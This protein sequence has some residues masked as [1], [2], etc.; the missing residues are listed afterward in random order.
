MN[1][2]LNIVYR[3]LLAASFLASLY[4][5]LHVGGLAQNLLGFPW[6]YVA[7][8]LTFLGCYIFLVYVMLNQ[9]IF[10]KIIEQNTPFFN[11]DDVNGSIGCKGEETQLIPWQKV[12]KIEILTTDKGPWEEDLWWLFH[13]ANVDDPIVIPQGVRNHNDLFYV[14]D[15]YFTDVDMDALFSGLVSVDNALF[16]IWSLKKNQ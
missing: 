12:I 4:I 13:L 3:L 11:H 7:L 8:L 16:N 2:F 10:K 5:G 6:N 9:V 15:K 1:L 14:L